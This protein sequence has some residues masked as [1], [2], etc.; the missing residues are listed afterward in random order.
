MYWIL[1]IFGLVLA[2]CVG[3]IVVLLV[4]AGRAKICRMNILVRLNKLEY[5]FRKKV[6]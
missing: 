4:R 5:E 6:E 2:W 1:V 3:A